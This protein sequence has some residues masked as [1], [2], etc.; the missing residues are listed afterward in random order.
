MKAVRANAAGF[1]ICQML[2]VVG[3]SAAICPLIR[4]RPDRGESA[5]S[6]AAPLATVVTSDTTLIAA[7]FGRQS[8]VAG[9]PGPV[10]VV[11][12]SITFSLTQIG[13]ISRRAI[14]GRS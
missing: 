3:L 13:E 12:M 9:W 10:G 8:T 6:L 1:G 5:W 4:T 11:V 7:V 2:R 14:R